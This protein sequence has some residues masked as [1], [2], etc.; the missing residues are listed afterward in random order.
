MTRRD[1]VNFARIN[2]AALSALPALVRRWL[3]GGK[4]EG[5][6]YVVPNPRRDDRR[7]GSFKINI[8]SGKWADF[9][10]NDRGGDPISLAAYLTDTTQIEAA[11]NLAKM[12]GIENV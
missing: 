1:H 2:A 5:V 4:A 11:R 12:L 10:T 8:R 7:P 6:E 3:P 9:A